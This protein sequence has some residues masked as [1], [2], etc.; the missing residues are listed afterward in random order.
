MGALALCQS[1]SLTK[2]QEDTRTDIEKMLNDVKNAKVG[3]SDF[4]DLE[5]ICEEQYAASLK[6][7]VELR[8]TNEEGDQW[9]EA[10]RTGKFELKSA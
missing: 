9:E 8:G 1:L 6:E 3:E 10:E 5:K 7:Q 2:A 4:A